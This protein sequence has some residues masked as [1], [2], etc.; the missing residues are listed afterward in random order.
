MINLYTSIAKLILETLES[1]L[2]KF[3]LCYQYFAGSCTKQCTQLHEPVSDSHT[4]K[5]LELLEIQALITEDI[6]RDAQSYKWNVLPADQIM[7]VVR[8]S[9]EL[10]LGELCR[11]E[12]P[13][14]TKYSA[15]ANWLEESSSKV[16]LS[17]YLEFASYLWNN[18]MAFTLKVFKICAHL[19]KQPEYF[20]DLLSIDDDSLF[21]R[22][23]LDIDNDYNNDKYIDAVTK[24]RSYISKTL[25]EKLPVDFHYLLEFIEKPIILS[26]FGLTLEKDRTISLPNSMTEKHLFDSSKWPL[27][28][29][30]MA[31]N[32]LTIIDQ[33]VTI[34]I[35]FLMFTAL[36]MHY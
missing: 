9:K 26:L 29:K 5:R 14:R 25:Q 11:L 4:R 18:D 22:M 24:T 17:S 20:E 36:K 16:V 3:N 33:Y 23:L 35:I 2:P 27:I 15:V 10:L 13:S 1:G 7:K 19:V 21:H 34:L 31:V 30:Q 8:K 12:V 6:K 28:Q 32:A